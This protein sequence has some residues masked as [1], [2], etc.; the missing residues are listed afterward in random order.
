MSGP[1]YDDR[2]ILQSCN[3]VAITRNR[4]LVLAALARAFGP[5]SITTIEQAVRREIRTPGAPDIGGYL[6]VLRQAGLA[7]SER[8]GIFSHWELT[9]LGREVAT[10]GGHAEAPDA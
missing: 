8:R 3:G 4:R 9:A 6:R 1:S 5:L 7:E 2:G 10:R